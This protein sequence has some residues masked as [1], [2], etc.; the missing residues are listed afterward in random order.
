MWPHEVLDAGDPGELRVGEGAGGVD[1]VGGPE[2]VTAVRGHGPCLGCL[3]PGQC[4]DPGGE[5]RI[6]VQVE[7]PRDPHRVAADLVAGGVLPLRYVSGLVEHRQVYVGLDVAVDARVPVPVPS[8]PEVTALLDD[9]DAVDTLP[10]Q[11]RPGEDAAESAAYHGDVDGV[12]ER[13]AFDRPFRVR[14]RGVVAEPGVRVAVL[15]GSVG[16]H[17]PFAFEP[18]APPQCGELV[19]GR[20][21]R[22]RHVGGPRSARWG[23]PGRAAVRYGSNYRT[24]LSG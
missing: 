16:T 6:R 14:V 18:V 10:A 1:D 22:S 20:C 3:F 12:V 4:G 2:G 8:A 21:L 19:G 9:P 15:G 5:Q 23:G 11:V 24:T 13:V 17:A 7:L